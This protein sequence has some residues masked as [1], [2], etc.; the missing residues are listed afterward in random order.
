M[1]A[2]ARGGDDSGASGD[3]GLTSPLVICGMHRSGTS[4]AASAFGRAGLALGSRL[5]GAGAGNPRGHFEDL[6]VW[7]LH[8]EMLAAAGHDAF[9]AGDDF[10]PPLSNGFVERARAFVA[11]RAGQ[12]AWG[13]KDP[14]TCLF[15]DLWQPLVPGAAWLVLYRH[16]ADVV[17]SLLRRDTEPELRAEPRLAFE[18][19]A[20]HNRRLLAFVERHRDRCFVAQ[21]P[22]LASDLEGLVA[23]VAER[24]ALP[25]E[26]AQA[27]SVLAADELARSLAEPER[28]AW[29]RVVPEALE[30]YR[31]LDA[32]ADLP[33]RPATEQ[34]ADEP[35]AATPASA[36]ARE[37]ARPELRLSEALLYDLCEA[38]ALRRQ[39][40]AAAEAFA[41]ALE[42][43][44]A[45]SASLRQELVLARD[46][47]GESEGR[48]DE[49]RH[50][51][52]EM[53]ARVD[54]AAARRDELAAALAAVER[55][56][57][58]RLV[59]GWWRLVAR[60]RRATTR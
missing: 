20:V 56:R 12:A 24:F 53:A 35:E 10:Q 22:A 55:S 48:A 16:P 60:L 25:L 29:E 26:P 7:R 2:P 14:R 21:A 52:L 3:T 19:W 6:D 41:A 54:D 49:L 17:L 30:L 8:E 15:L 5:N 39:Q 47:V 1:C 28:P 36:A 37:R 13:W 32:L 42:E 9:S 38:R 43:E 46:R 59:A 50:R 40:R 45:Q 31:R 51:L 23:R 58:F 11:A 57:S 33:G 27:A 34:D 4:L 44:R 18:S